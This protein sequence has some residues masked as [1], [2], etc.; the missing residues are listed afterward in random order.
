M[1]F[2]GDN[3]TATFE[4]MVHYNV[5]L[6]EAIFELLTEKGVLTGA[7]V[8]DRVKKLRAETKINFR[9]PN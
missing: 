7:E 4:E 8:L 2:A 5:L 9:R 3:V 1:E 6:T